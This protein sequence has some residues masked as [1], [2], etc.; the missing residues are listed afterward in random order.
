LRLRHVEGLRDLPIPDLEA[1]PGMLSRICETVIV[2]FVVE[3]GA[4][5]A[6][7]AA[8]I[9]VII[10]SVTF[11]VPPVCNCCCCAVRS[12]SVRATSA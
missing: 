4:M 9:L 5:I 3:Y 12:A 11:V 8:K 10:V 6:F 2:S 7:D 1:E